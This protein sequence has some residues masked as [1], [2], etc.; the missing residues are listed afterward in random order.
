MRGGT[1]T[2]VVGKAYCGCVGPGVSCGRVGARGGG[3]GE[4]SIWAPPVGWLS[5]LSP[6]PRFVPYHQRL[7]P[8]PLMIA[9]AGSAS[10]DCTV[11][12]ADGPG[13]I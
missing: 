12:P 1:E 8:V 11:S 7:T 5:A 13:G 10:F 2:V 3:D 6:S 9:H 4:K